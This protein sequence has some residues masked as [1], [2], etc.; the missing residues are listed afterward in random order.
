MVDG[1]MYVTS[2]FHRLF[3]PDAETGRILWEFDPRFDRYTRVTL[4]FSRG[5]A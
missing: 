2:S 3:A 5:V 4:H 1:V